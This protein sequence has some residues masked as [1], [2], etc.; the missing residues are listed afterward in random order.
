ML[1]IFSTARPL[2]G[3][4]A[5]QQRNAIRS[6]TSLRPAPDIVLFGDED[7]VADICRELGLIHVPHVA[8]TEFGMPLVNDMFLKAQGLSRFDSLCYVNSDIV[9]MSDFG[10]A[11]IRIKAWSRQQPF[12]MVGKHREVGIDEPLDFSS[13]WEDRVR[14]LLS[15]DG[16]MGPALALDWFA[17]S[18]GLF[19]DM[20]QFA[21][22]RAGWDN[23]MVYGARRCGARV[24]DTSVV[25]SA[26]HQR[27]DYSH[28]PDGQRGVHT[29]PE[30]EYNVRLARSQI[31][32]PLW[33]FG[34]YDATHVLTESGVAPAWK[35]KGLRNWLR[36]EKNRIELFHPA[37][38]P[39]FRM[40]R[41]ILQLG[42]R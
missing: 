39:A 18:R 6:W 12:L 4:P 19:V 8:R 35:V 10:R 5:L 11:L 42:R 26:V 15:R 1:T 40:G 3:K 20:P 21:V 13:H 41:G 22:G 30:A 31:P 38:G 29:G 14:E 33:K 27:H 36:W 24:I 37:L 34:V 17:F 2:T 16:Q 28:H 9:L 25:V 32:G 23:W 7:G